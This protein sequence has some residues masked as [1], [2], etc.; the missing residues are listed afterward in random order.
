MGL[1]IGIGVG[2]CFA[3]AARGPQL[4]SLLGKG[5]APPALGR[6]A[7]ANSFFANATAG[8]P[9]TTDGRD[10]VITWDA[11]AAKIVSY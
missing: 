2:V 7:V 8:L 4:I 1:A 11:G 9:I 10:V 5:I 3:S 6:P